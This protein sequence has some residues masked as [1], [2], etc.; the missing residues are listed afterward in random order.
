MTST[1]PKEVIL[2]TDTRGRVFTPAA[3]RERLLDEFERSG[4]SGAKFAELTGLKYST[5]A[6]WAQRRRRQRGAPTPPSQKASAT[7]G[8]WLEAVV[9]Q[10]ALREGADP[11]RVRLASGAWVELEHAGQ[12]PLV[13]ALLRAWEKAAPAC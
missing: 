9:E 1:Q 12:A 6:T 5:F 7:P 13:A 2:K 11:V 10:A 8:Q 4:L 3:R